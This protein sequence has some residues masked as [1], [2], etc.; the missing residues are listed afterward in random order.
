MHRVL[1]GKASDEEVAELER[2]LSLDSANT[3]EFEEMKLLYSDSWELQHVTRTASSQSWNKIEDAIH[4]IQARE[5]RINSLK[6]MGMA[7]GIYFLVIFSYNTISIHGRR[8]LRDDHLT[9][10]VHYKDA[11]ISEVMNTIQ[12]NYQFKITLASSQLEACKFTGSFKGGTSIREVIETV[13]KAKDLNVNY[14]AEQTV[15]LSGY[16]CKI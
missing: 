1:I 2:W 15:V 7:T 3:M 5:R 11:R 8:A 13:A 12:E 6:R 9:Q 14:T 16:P 10:T 4:S